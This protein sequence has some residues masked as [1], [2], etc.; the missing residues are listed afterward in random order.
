LT[1]ASR[2]C[3]INW[4][5]HATPNKR[6]VSIRNEKDLCMTSNSA[7]ADAAEAVW[8]SAVAA[9]GAEP[10]SSSKKNLRQCDGTWTRITG[11]PCHRNVT[12]NHFELY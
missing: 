4:T 9:G 2:V 3:V 10:L 7:Q 12:I 6:I 1:V 11:R 5:G 8:R